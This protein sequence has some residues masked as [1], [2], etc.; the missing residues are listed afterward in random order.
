[1]SAPVINLD[2]LS[3][4][5]ITEI[6]RTMV[7]EIEAVTENQK[8]LRMAYSKYQQS[9]KAVESLQKSSQ[10]SMLVV[11]HHGFYLQR[12]PLEDGIDMIRRQSQQNQLIIIT[13]SLVII[14][15]FFPL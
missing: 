12:H 15:L 14:F 3:P 8:A 9:H 4:Q 10:K 7:L 13:I 5:E 2:T 11:F 6:H 1:M